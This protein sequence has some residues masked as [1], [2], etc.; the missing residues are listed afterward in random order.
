MS[1]V[2]P[3]LDYL[4]AAE[5]LDGSRL[6]QT[7]ED[8]SASHP[9]KSAF[10]DLCQHNEYGGVLTDEHGLALVRD[11]IAFFGITNGEHFYVVDLRDGHF[12]LDHM[13]FFPQP[14]AYPDIPPG[15]RFSLLYF[16]DHQQDI[17]M[18]PDGSQTL[19]AHR[20][21]YRLGWEYSLPD[22]RKWQQTIIVR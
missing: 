18:A 16:R 8:V 11:D 9:T 5:F 22:G 7:P 10:Y 2:T 3:V 14:T 4:F 1:V 17:I 6:E 19:G 12:E 20:M 21:A 13:P 15:G